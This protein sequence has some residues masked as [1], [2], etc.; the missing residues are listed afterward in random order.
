MSDTK[1]ETR[2]LVNSPS[3]SVVDAI[4]QVLVSGNLAALTPEQRVN[5]YNKTCESLG[6][7]PLTRPFEYITL[8]GK[9]TFYARKDCTEQLRSNRKVSIAIAAREVVEGVYV[10]TARASDASGRTDESIGAV[11]IDKLQGESRANA[12]MKAE[13][14]AKRRVTLS[15]C[16]LGML[17]ETEVESIPGVR[18]EASHQA[19]SMARPIDAEVVRSKPAPSEPK[20]SPESVKALCIAMT[21]LGIKDREDV[22]AWCSEKVGRAVPSRKDLTVSECSRCIEEAR[23]PTTESSED[24]KPDEEG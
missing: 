11:P 22:L 23:K 7:N 2:S 17:D 4:E 21:A 9:L 16:G 8:N 5:Y 12:M 18:F 1:Q 13:T 24:R 6:L 10:V 3:T 14:K 15:F 20:A 19:T